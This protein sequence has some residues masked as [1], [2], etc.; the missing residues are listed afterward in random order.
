MTNFAV[1]IGWTLTAA[2]RSYVPHMDGY[3]PGAPQHQVTIPVE[4]TNHPTKLDHETLIYLHLDANQ[5]EEDRRL[6][7]ATALAEHVF[8]ATNGPHLMNPQ[9][10]TGQIA[11]LIE[12]SGYRGLEAGHYSLSVGDTV[13]VEG[14]TLACG[15]VGWSQV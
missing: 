7:M 10:L 8:E 6:R 14:I 12:D 15:K 11:Q 1:T 9:G 5:A 3:R 4:W 2:D 13:T